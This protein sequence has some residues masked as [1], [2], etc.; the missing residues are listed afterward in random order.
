NQNPR[1]LRKTGVAPSTLQESGKQRQEHFLANWEGGGVPN[2]NKVR[3]DTQGCSPP[4][5]HVLWHA[6]VSTHTHKHRSSNT[7]SQ[8]GGWGEGERGGFF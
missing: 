5:T 2:W 7:G 6:L 3:A 1:T 4:S 8:C